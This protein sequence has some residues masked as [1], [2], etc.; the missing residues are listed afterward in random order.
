MNPDINK[1]YEKMSTSDNFRISNKD[2]TIETG[3]NSSVV[4]KEPLNYS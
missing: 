2:L 1:T 4:G 3:Y